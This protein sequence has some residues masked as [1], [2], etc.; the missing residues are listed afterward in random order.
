MN[1]FHKQRY[2]NQTVSTQRFGYGT[3]DRGNDVIIQ[4]MDILF[5]F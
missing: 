2:T 3:R 1:Q 4:Q 5:C